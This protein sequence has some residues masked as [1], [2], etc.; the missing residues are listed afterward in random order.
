MRYDARNCGAGWKARDRATGAEIRRVVWVD[1]AAR[2]YAQ[3]DDPTRV[4]GNAIASTTYHVHAI[5]VDA[6]ARTIWITHRAGDVSLTLRRDS[7]QPKPGEPC[8]VCHQ[9]ETCAR[10]HYCPAYRC[11]FGEVD[12]P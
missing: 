5:D 7:R 12:K 9:P 2:S 8:D 11:R 6:P 4:V 10:I 3:H 1:T